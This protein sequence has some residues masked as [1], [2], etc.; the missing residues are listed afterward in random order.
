ML[1]VECKADLTLVKALSNAPIKGIMHAGNKSGV[2]SKLVRARGRPNYQNSIG[3]IDQDPGSSQSS[4]LKKF[5]EVKRYTELE[6]NLFRYKWLNNHL[7]MLCPRLE[8]WI[9]AASREAGVNLSKY[10]LS[11]NADMLHEV[12]N[13]NLGKFESLLDELKVKSKRVKKL[14][15]CISSL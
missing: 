11:T 7:V 9:I 8:E 3:M 12:I 4:D 1:F 15:N 6:I 13:I 10:N 2:L 5:I 14:A